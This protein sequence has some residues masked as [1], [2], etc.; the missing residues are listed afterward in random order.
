V[1]SAVTSAALTMVN[2]KTPVSAR[3]QNFILL[4]SPMMLSDYYIAPTGRDH[5]F[6]SF[7]GPE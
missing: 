7:P 1:Y 4:V 3:Q 2:K 6:Q 5:L